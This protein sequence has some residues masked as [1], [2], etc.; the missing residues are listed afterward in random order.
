MHPAVKTLAIAFIAFTVPMVVAI[1]MNWETI[2][3]RVNVTPETAQG[4]V[5]Y[6]TAPD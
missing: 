1:G 5:L 2:Q 3:S 4:R 6:F